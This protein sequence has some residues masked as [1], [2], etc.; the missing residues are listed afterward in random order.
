M[1]RSFSTR[2]PTPQTSTHKHKQTLCNIKFGYVQVSR[3]GVAAVS[4]ID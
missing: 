2:P 4:R 3:Y 1:M